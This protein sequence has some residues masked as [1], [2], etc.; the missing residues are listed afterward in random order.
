MN[1][2]DIYTIVHYT[3]NG[4]DIF[5][6]WRNKLRDIRAKI[7]IDRAI[8]NMEKGNFGVHRFCR[9]SVSE[10]VI[11]TGPGYRVYYS[12][13]GKTIILLLCGGDKSTQQRDIDK[14]VDYLKKY[15]EEHP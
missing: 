2:A 10:L 15:K 9:D 5:G 3:E 13:I 12:I 7:A 8:I 1:M 14:A 6:Q 11:N 4:R